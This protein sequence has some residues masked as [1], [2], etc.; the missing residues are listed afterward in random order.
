[1]SKQKKATES[2]QEEPSAAGREPIAAGSEPSADGEGAAQKLQES[3][4]PKVVKEE[5]GPAQPIGTRLTIYGLGLAA[6]FFLILAA[7]QMAA[8]VSE[9]RASRRALDFAHGDAIMLSAQS[10]AAA[11]EPAVAWRSLVPQT[12][13]GSLQGIVQ[14]MLRS[15]AYDLVAILDGTGMVIA[16]SDLATVGRRVEGVEAGEFALKKVG[17]AWQATAPIRS[18]DSTV[19]TVVLRERPKA[20]P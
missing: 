17:G 11:I 18:V 14:A 1:M 10:V 6:V 19:G 20:S 8:L 7:W 3:E 16:S 5:A 15:D 2:S 13:V 12:S 9:R 4:A